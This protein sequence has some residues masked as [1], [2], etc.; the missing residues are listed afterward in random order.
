M[1][2]LKCHIPI[3]SQ[4]A[5]VD[6]TTVDPTLKSVA[7]VVCQKTFSNEALLQKHLRSAHGKVQQYDSDDDADHEDV[8]EEEGEGDEEKDRQQS[9]G[10]STSLNRKKQQAYNNIKLNSNKRKSIGDLS[11]EDHADLDAAL[12][13]RSVLKD[14]SNQDGCKPI[15]KKRKIRAINNN[16]LLINNNNLPLQK[17]CCP[18]C[19][20]NDFPSMPSLEQHLDHDHPSV[21]PKCRHCAYTFKSHKQLNGHQ[22]ADKPLTNSRHSGN[23]S[24]QVTQGFKDLTFMDFSSDKFPYIAKSICEQSIRTPIA[25]QKFECHRCFRAFPCG[26]ALDIH[27]SD[28]A[29]TRH[30]TQHS[31]MNMS[32]QSDPDCSAALAPTRREDFFANLDLQNKSI[33]SSSSSSALKNHNNSASMSA[34]HLSPQSSPT[35]TSSAPASP[36]PQAISKQFHHKYQEGMDFSQ[37]AGILPL[38]QQGM[39]KPN[40][41]GKD[42]ADIESIINVTAASG[43]FF[44]HFSANTTTTNTT[45][46]SSNKSV[47]LNS[48]LNSNKDEEEAQDAFTSEFRKMKLR[49]EFPCKLCTAVYPNLRALKGHNRLHLGA[50][51][52]G[53]YRCNMCPFFINDK[54]ALIRHMRYVSQINQLRFQLL[55]GRVNASNV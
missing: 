2:A 8:E 25:K 50:A 6:A 21:P 43:G 45:N 4:A 7:C 40:H 23:R 36:T 24:Q 33:A 42:L 37:F 51:G 13:E 34:S 19:E 10:S 1:A 15:I 26:A 35:S 32:L 46:S 14:N 5:S 54:A 29:A 20:R 38:H 12:Q 9:S 44:R 18:L 39:Q 27:Q 55:A 41:D 31:I 17:Y 28:C 53:P 11:D 48:S 49:G 22:C 3:H 30:P 47:D 52:T 16:N